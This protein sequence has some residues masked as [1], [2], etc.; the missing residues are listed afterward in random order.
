MSSDVSLLLVSFLAGM[1]VGLTSMG[2]AAIITPFLVLVL[3]VRPV[4]AVGTDL[5]YGAVTKIVGAFMHWRQGTVDLAIVGRLALGS[6]PGGCLG[7][8]AIRYLEARNVPVDDFLRPVLGVILMLVALVILARTLGWVPD[9]APAWLER[10]PALWTVIW[11]FLIGTAVGLTSVGSGSLLIPFLILVMKDQSPSRVVGTDVFHAAILI[12]ATAGL[13]V[14]A[15]NVNWEPV[16]HLLLGSIPG[17]LLGSYLAPRVPARG[18]RIG[19]GVVL[20]ATGFKL[21]P[22]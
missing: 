1:L 17:V 15:G 16:P 13:Y 9:H 22:V 12:T 18:V 19:L 10:S 21:I 11:G 20:F 3:G 5:V 6:L 2:G 14:H 8:F 4:L 7:V